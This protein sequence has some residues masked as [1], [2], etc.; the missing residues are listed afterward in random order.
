MYVLTPYEVLRRNGTDVQK[1]KAYMW[2]GSSEAREAKK[3][4]EGSPGGLVWS[5]LPHEFCGSGLPLGSG[6]WWS[7][8]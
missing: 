7:G 1:G 6:W 3:L 8:P 5:E 2:A 4:E